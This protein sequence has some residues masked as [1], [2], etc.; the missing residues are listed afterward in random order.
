VLTVRSFD[1]AGTQ[2][3]DEFILSAHKLV[4]EAIKYLTANGYTRLIVDVTGNG[5]GFVPLGIDTVR[6]LFPDKDHF[7]AVNMRWSPAL[8]TMLT[9][10]K[11]SNGTYWDYRTFNDEQ[12]RDVK[13]MQQHLGPTHRDND[14]FTPIVRSDAVDSTK[15]VG[16]SG[17]DPGARQPFETKNVLLVCSPSPSSP[18]SSR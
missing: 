16:I 3:A 17:S 15:A 18:F 10:G 7:F 1:P 5:G 14:W 8:S 4:K 11:D 12:G 13:S 6:Q 2:D 9:Q